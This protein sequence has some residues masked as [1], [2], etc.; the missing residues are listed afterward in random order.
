MIASKRIHLLDFDGVVFRNKKAANYVATRAAE[1]TRKKMGM[2][3]DGSLLLAKHLN[4]ILYNKYGHTTLGL[5]NMGIKCDLNEFNEFIYTDF[6]YSAFKE[7]N[8]YLP[9]LPN[10]YLFS[11]APK[12][13]CQKILGH[14][15]IVFIEDIIDKEEMLKPQKKLY[16]K[17]DDYFNRSEV[18]FV[19]DS[20][21]NIMPVLNKE[22]WINVLFVEDQPTKIVNNMITIGDLGCV[23]ML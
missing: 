12:E 10:M 17:I 22:N 15:E 20:L 19:E 7:E 5:K 18:L 4:T 16:N 13:Y 3:G 1:Y 14:R 9:I 11:N 6:P 2:K 8:M 23:H 21:I